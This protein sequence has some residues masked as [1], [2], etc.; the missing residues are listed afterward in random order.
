MTV[1]S[2][3]APLLASMDD[4]VSDQP[5][6]L[7]VKKK[8]TSTE[9]PTSPA[10]C[11]PDPKIIETAQLSVPAI[12][13][14]IIDDAE[15]ALC[16]A[17]QQGRWS[18]F[19]AALVDASHANTDLSSLLCQLD[20]FEKATPLHWAVINGRYEMT[21]HLLRLGANCNLVGGPDASTPLHW[22]AVY[23]SL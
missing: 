10:S 2:V 17:T 9:S 15:W 7:S 22:A 12:Q 1:T 8:A 23:A 19:H 16:Q 14:C 3:R 21:L 11:H 13:K 4:L 5:V 18:L 6:L 20:P